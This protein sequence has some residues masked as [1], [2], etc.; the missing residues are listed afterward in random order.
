MPPIM[1]LIA[2]VGA[3]VLFDFVLQGE[4]LALAK[5]RFKPVP[6][7]P[8]HIAMSAH[9][10]L[11]ATAVAL[12]TG[13]PILFLAEWILHF[14]IDDFKCSDDI[15]YTTDQWLHLGC[16]VVWWT[17]VMLLCPPWMRYW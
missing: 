6:G 10:T 2:L 1:M 15:S 3:H 8:W 13:V 17:F 4:Y 5:N 16:K 7:V 9:A 12:I 11:H 14:C